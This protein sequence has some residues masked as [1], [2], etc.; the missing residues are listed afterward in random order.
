MTVRLPTILAKAIEDVV[1][2]L[3]EQSDRDRIEDLVGCIKRMEVLMSDLSTNQRLRPIIDDG[4]ADVALWNKEIAMFFKGKDFLTATWVFAEAYKY[5]RLHEC[6]SVS[7]YWKV[8]AA[9]LCWMYNLAYSLSSG[10]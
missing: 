6:F 4:E 3:N 7:R 1:R 5:R 9:A 10:L 8:C 2:T